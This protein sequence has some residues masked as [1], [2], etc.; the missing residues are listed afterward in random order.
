MIK[1]RDFIA[2][3]FGGDQNKADEANRIYK[4][5]WDKVNPAGTPASGLVNPFSKEYHP[6]LAFGNVDDARTAASVWDRLVD[7]ANPG[8]LTPAQEAAAG[9]ANGT[10]NDK[11]IDSTYRSLAAQKLGE[12]E[13]MGNFSYDFNNDPIFKSLSASYMQQARDAASN[14]SALAAARTGGYGN[15]YGA[16]AAA[17]QYNRALNDLYDQIPDLEQAAYNRWQNQKN[18][19]YTQAGNY[20]TLANDAY[21]RGLTADETQYTREQDKRTQEINEAVTA[22]QLGNYDLIEK[23]L[24]V[25]MSD[26]RTAD[27][28]NQFISIASLLGEEGFAQMVNGLTSSS[29]SELDTPVIDVGGG[30]LYHIPEDKEENGKKY[31]YYVADNMVMVEIT[32]ADGN[33]KREQ[34]TGDVIGAFGGNIMNLK[35]GEVREYTPVNDTLGKDITGTGSDLLNAIISAVIGGGLAKYGSSY[36]TSNPIPLT[37]YVSSSFGGY[38][39]WDGGYDYSGNQQPEQTDIV[40]KAAE[41]AVDKQSGGGNGGG[42]YSIGSG[43]G[44][45]SGGNGGSKSEQKTVTV[46]EVPVTDEFWNSI[47]FEYPKKK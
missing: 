42:G 31:H 12:A 5:E 34:Y 19:L 38:G 47:G 17:Q 16:T 3:D 2:S 46:T 9:V 25:D 37:S 6:V 32:D 45:Y 28:V 41:I 11:A 13:G 1:P 10:L 43:G 33:L 14:A 18:D 21:S 27:K 36:N 4:P 7:E 24:G 35:T 30:Q 23:V 22:A 44:D 40:Q 15:S 8:N 20:Q 26:A 29:R 39:G